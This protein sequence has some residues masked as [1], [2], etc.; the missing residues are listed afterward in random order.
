M[1]REPSICTAL[2]ITST[3]VHTKLFSRKEYLKEK[4]PSFFTEMWTWKKRQLAKTKLKCFSI[5]V[6]PT[7]SDGWNPVNCVNYQCFPDVLVPNMFLRRWPRCLEFW[8]RENTV[9]DR[10]TRNIWRC[11]YFIS[12]LDNLVSQWLSSWSTNHSITSLKNLI[13]NKSQGF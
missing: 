12:P 1:S 13:V 11:Q 4:A 10:E 9:S 3:Y 7:V 5:V 6:L 8:I 2:K